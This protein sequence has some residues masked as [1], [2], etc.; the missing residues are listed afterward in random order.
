[1]SPRTTMVFLI[2][3]GSR[4]HSVAFR[5]IFH[6]MVFNEKTMAVL[7]ADQRS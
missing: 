7:S 3:S 1:M 4:S 6:S 2:L 5:E